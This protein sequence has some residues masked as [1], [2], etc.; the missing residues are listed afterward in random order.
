MRPVVWGV[1]GAA[2]IATQKVVPGMKGSP[3][4]DM[5]AIAS[6]DIAKARAAAAELGLAKAYGSYEEMLGDP[7][8]EA[9]YNPLPNHLHVPWTVKALEAGKHVLCEKPIALTAAEAR[10]LVAARDRTGKL[11]AEAFMV[12]FH[13]QWRRTR[14]IVW[15][16]GIGELRSIATQFNYNNPDPANI[17]N[18]ADIGG[19]G[20]YDIGCYAILTARFIFGVEPARAV[21]LIDRDPVMKTDRLTGALV[22]FGDGRQLTFSVS[23]QTAPSQRVQIFGTKGRVEIPV[24]FNPVPAME[25][26]IIVDDCRDLYGGGARTET[27]A[28]C[29]QYLLQGEAFARAVR[30]SEKFPYPVED[31]IANMRAIDALYR[32][33]ETGNWEKV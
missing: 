4:L 24:P 5:R 8:I 2:R 23:T 16:G 6:R 33:A 30:G 31:A 18:K 20:L 17:R 19:G 1:L 11:V 15:A 9:V 32:S 7:E 14:E 27:F 10:D 3:L 21:S 28:P 12:R 25:S 22:D 13:P 26:R 29:D